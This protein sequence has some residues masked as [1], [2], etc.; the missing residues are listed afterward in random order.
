MLYE[1]R[2]AVIRLFNDYSSI[3][4][5]DKHKAKY[6]EGLKILTPKQILERLPIALAQIKAGNTSGNIPN[7]IT[8]IIYF[9]CRANKINK[10]V[11]NSIMNP[12][13][14]LSRMDTIF[15]DS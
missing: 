13:N 8:Q 11:Y 7:E 3:V 5:E 12:I 6:G 9:L 14:L 10:K 15:M 2:E 4:S 1:S